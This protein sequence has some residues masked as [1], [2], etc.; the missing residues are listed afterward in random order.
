VWWQAE[1]HALSRVSD[2]ISTVYVDQAV[3]G[4]DGN[5]IVLVDDAG[6]THLP[7]ATIACLL[8]GPGTRTTH[9]AARLLADSGTTMCW[10][11]ENGVRM[12]AHGVATAQSSRLL[13]RQ[14]WLVADIRRRLGVARRMYEMR[15]PGEDVTKLTMQQ[16]RGR[17]GARVRRA[18]RAESERTGVPWI[19]RQ[20]VPGKAAAAGDDVNRLL[21]ALNTCLYGVAHAAIVGVGASAGLGF[22]HTGSTISFVLD[23]ADLYKADV[24]IPAAFDLAAEGAT[25][26]RAARLRFRDQVVQHRLMPRI[27]ADVRGLLLGDEPDDAEPEAGT[28]AADR[29]VDADG[30]LAGGRNHAAAW[31]VWDQP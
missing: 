29:L 12:Y 6:T 11:G 30:E 2:R 5:A 21:S 1:T 19:G 16:L 3:I 9:A 23:V 7:A 8:L 28:P 4:R 26:E 20:Y 22:V 18:Y 25:G 24:T 27:V 13:L 17:E 14:A 10:V 15:F 31:A